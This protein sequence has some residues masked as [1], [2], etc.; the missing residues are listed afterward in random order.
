MKSLI[1]KNIGQ[2]VTFDSG[3]EKLK[4]YSNTDLLLNNGIIQKIGPGLYGTGSEIDCRFCL[5]TP[6]F[7][8][9]HT[10][11]VFTAGRQDEF[12]QRLQGISY[13][14][15]AQKGGGIKASIQG[16]RECTEEE[17]EKKVRKRMDRFLRLGTTT[18]EAKSGYGLNLD[19][20]LKS[21]RILSRINESH[22]LDIIPTFM[23]AHAFP[24]EFEQDHNGYIDLICEKMIPAV[25][26]ENLA[27]FCDVFCEEGYFSVDQSRRILKM[28][29]KYGL[30][31]RLHADEF[32]DSKAAELAAELG[33]VSADHLM[34]VS[35]Q[36]LK[37]LSQS[38]VIA[39][40]LPGTTFFLGKSTYAPA[41]ELL[42]NGITVALGTDYNPG[43]SHIQSMPFIISLACLQMG[44]TVEEAF[45]SA[46][47]NSARALRQ[48]KTMGSLE[49][50]K[51]GD[52]IV[53]DL[54]KLSEIPYYV[55]D[56]PINTV[57]KSGEILFRLDSPE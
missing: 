17:L 57:I 46:T 26:A 19:S 18:V 36:G 52:L 22:A 16:V 53:W 44:M 4:I 3:A 41:G 23:G 38:N 15:I 10:H 9:P 39:T 5:V 42:R 25:A 32:I 1:L 33:A 48:E 11:P 55:V 6:G 47:F 28:A 27:Q 13:E 24:P 56:S 2:L 51:Q 29:Q 20:E 12:L 45:I 21:L 35:E 49:I 54:E 31:A 40:L 30:G 43:S 14:E 37:A 7:I 8:D 50:G 34:A